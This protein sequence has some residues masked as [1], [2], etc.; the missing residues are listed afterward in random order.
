M[1]TGISEQ[2]VTL[3][4]QIAAAEAEIENRHSRRKADVK[5][6]ETAEAAEVELAELTQV[7]EFMKNRLSRWSPASGLSI[8]ELSAG[9]A[10]T[11]A[12]ARRSDARMER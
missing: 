6:R 11:L 10:C 4:E 12:I 1:D 7:H 5:D 3:R 9:C 2:I 8:L